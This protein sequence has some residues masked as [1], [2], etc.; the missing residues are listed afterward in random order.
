[1]ISELDLGF[2]YLF[3]L[4]GEDSLL[5]CLASFM[6]NLIWML[7]VPSY[8]PVVVVDIERQAHTEIQSVIKHFM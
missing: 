3:Y 5:K 8:P 2:Q 1:M 6:G 7:V 4:M